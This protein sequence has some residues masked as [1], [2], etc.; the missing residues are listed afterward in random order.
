MKKSFGVVG[1][2]AVDIYA[3]SRYFKPQVTNRHQQIV[4]DHGSQIWLDSTIQEPGGSGLLAAMVFARQGERVSLA[5]KT[6]ADIFSQIITKVAQDESIELYD[7]RETT[8][9]HTDSIIHLTSEK[10][11][12]TIMRYS[13]SFLS[14]SRSDCNNL[15]EDLDWLHIATLPAE[16]SIL[17]YLIKIAQKSHIALSI[18]PHFI[19]TL[20]SRTLLKVLLQCEIVILNRD[21]ASILLGTYCNI[22]QAAHKLYEIGLKHIV[23]YDDSEGVAVATNNLM[24]ETIGVQQSKVIDSSGAEEV[25]AAGYVYKYLHSQDINQALTFGLAQA[26]SVGLIAGARAGILKNPVLEP[27]KVEQYE[28]KEEIL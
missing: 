7:D 27:I 22:A 9:H 6:G 26:S 14:L 12:Q 13:G 17:Q 25:F 2:A 28:F 15:P 19:H 20:P 18:N 24:Y 16:K 4:I 3:V 1:S 23:V 21:E 8:K 5:T 11:D 10:I